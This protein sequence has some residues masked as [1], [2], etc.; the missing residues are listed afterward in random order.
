[1]ASFSDAAAATQNELPSL[2]QK[3]PEICPYLFPAPV[4]FRAPTRDLPMIA[5]IPQLIRC[6]ITTKREIPRDHAV[7][8]ARTAT[9]HGCTGC[10]GQTITDQC[11]AGFPGIVWVELDGA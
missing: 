10:T 2:I 11:A 9:G 6:G 7:T 5:V 1:M 4:N 8:R 3:F